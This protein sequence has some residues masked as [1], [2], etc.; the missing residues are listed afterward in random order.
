M[1]TIVNTNIS[2]LPKFSETGKLGSRRLNLHVKKNEPQKIKAGFSWLPQLGV[3]PILFLQSSIILRKLFQIINILEYSEIL[4]K[5]KMKRLY[6]VLLL[7]KMMM[8]CKSVPSLKK[9][10]PGDHMF[11]APWSKKK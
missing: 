2:P 4:Q 7:K 1:L 8:L 11:K 5:H 9:V 10:R 6:W 3:L